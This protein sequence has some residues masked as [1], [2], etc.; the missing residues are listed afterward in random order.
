MQISN[1]NVLQEFAAGRAPI[2]CVLSQASG[3]YHTG[4]HNALNRMFH[5]YRAA[6]HRNRR[7]EARITKMR[8]GRTLVDLYLTESGDKTKIKNHYCGLTLYR[9]LNSFLTQ[10][11]ALG[12][13]VSEIGIQSINLPNADRQM[14][15]KDLEEWERNTGIKVTMYVTEKR[16]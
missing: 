2:L 9:S 5:L 6:P 13:V 14:V 1:L 12:I 4:I 8:K 10:A 7:G 16:R 11:Q 15:Q 3:R